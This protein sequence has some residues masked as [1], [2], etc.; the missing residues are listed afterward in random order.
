MTNVLC[1]GSR[2]S[3]TNRRFH[4][5]HRRGDVAAFLQIGRRRQ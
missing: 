5:R 2:T 4:E 1:A 3:H